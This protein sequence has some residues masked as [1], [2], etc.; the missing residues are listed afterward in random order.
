MKRRMS[1]AEVYKTIAIYD[2]ENLMSFADGWSRF[3]EGRTAIEIINSLRKQAEFWKSTSGMQHIAEVI[4][5]A[6]DE[7]VTRLSEM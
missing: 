6:A 5:C 2:N 1:Y 3:P 7:M 4:D